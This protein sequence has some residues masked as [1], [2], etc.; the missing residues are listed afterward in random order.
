[1]P[2]LEGYFQLFMAEISHAILENKG[3]WAKTEKGCRKCIFQ[4]HSPVNALNFDYH[5]VSVWVPKDLP[6]TGDDTNC[7]C[8]PSQ[9]CLQV[10]S[11]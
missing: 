2:L 5:S 11:D 1:M 6:S 10:S 8:V 9:S 3:Y 7:M 4:H